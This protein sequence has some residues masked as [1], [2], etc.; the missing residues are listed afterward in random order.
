MQ[1][2]E[3]IVDILSINAPDFRSELHLPIALIPTQ[4]LL[5]LGFAHSTISSLFL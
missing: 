3:R 4:L 5:F 1:A 2:Y